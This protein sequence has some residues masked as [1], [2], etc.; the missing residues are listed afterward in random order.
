MGEHVLTQ[1]RQDL[2]AHL[3]QD[4]GLQIHTHHGNHQNRGICAHHGK[5]L[6]QGEVILD[7]ILNLTNQHRRNQVVG[8]G[9]QHNHKHQ[10][11]LGKIGLGITQQPPDNHRVG[12][13]ALELLHGLVPLDLCIG[14]QKGDG[15][16]ADDGTHNENGQ[17][18]I[19]CDARLLP[20]PA[21]AAPPSCGTPRRCR[22][23]PDGCRKPPRCRHQ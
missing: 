12:H 15:K 13:L 19:H 8:N 4:H 21:S 22:T 3:L 18:L 16:D 5:E 23:V 14:D 17:I 6:A 2:L 1:V 10:Q 7:Q 20:L 11:K 9:D